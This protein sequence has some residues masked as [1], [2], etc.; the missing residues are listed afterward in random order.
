M[1]AIRS[2]YVESA[3]DVDGRISNGV[4]RLAEEA[5][6]EGKIRYMGFTGHSSP[7]AFLRMMEQTGN[8]G[9][10]STIQCPVNPVDAQ[11]EH[12]FIKKVLPQAIDHKLGILAMKS[13]AAGRL[14]GKQYWAGR[15]TWSSETPLVPNYIQM[16]EIF[17]F[18]RNNFV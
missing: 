16:E 9:L 1:Y 4:L 15:L 13:L 11:S 17:R 10:F 12:S 2:Y 8:S 6:K 7:Y 18:I 3:E 5:L 14:L